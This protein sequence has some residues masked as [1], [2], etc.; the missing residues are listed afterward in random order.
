M[1]RYALRCIGGHEFEAW[2]SN[3]AA[4]D[5]QEKRGQ[6]ECPDCG[7]RDVSKQIMAPA[8]RDSGGKSDPS[9]DAIAARVAGEVRRHIATTHDY[10]GDRFADEARSMYYGER[11]HRPVWGQ[12]TPDVARELHEEGVP[13]MPL[14]KPFAPD[15]PP[16]PDKIN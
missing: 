7:S 1:I 9:R 16:D 3:S 4:Y 14:P 10:V 5:R 2:F 13:A 11:E 15:P 12:V 8:V 6:I